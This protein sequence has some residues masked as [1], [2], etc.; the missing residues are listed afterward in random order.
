MFKRK[1]KIKYLLIF[2]CFL[3]AVQAWAGSV[4]TL[5][6]LDKDR[7]NLIINGD[8]RVSQRA[9]YTLVKDAYAYGA[10]D[11]FSG[12]AT[13]T[14]VSAG[15]LA[16]SSSAA[17]GRTGYAVHFSAATL[18]GTGIIYLRHRIEARDALIY[19][20]Q[21]ISF[22]SKVYQ[23]TGGSVNYTIYIRKANSADNFAAVTNISNSGAISVATA[24]ATNLNY[25]AIAAGDC[26]NGL[27]VE[28][29]VECGAVNNK[30]FYFAELQLE[31]GP[32]VTDFK[33]LPYAQTRVMCERYY[34]VQGGVLGT[35]PII[36]AYG[37]A[38]ATYGHGF[39]FLT[40]KRTTPTITKVGTWTVN[41]CG[42]PVVTNPSSNGYWIYIAVT[43]DGRYY[44]FP[45]DATCVVT[46]DAEL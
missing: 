33:F 5:G 15:S 27:E 46:A 40:N 24:T 21:T 39:N 16:Q 37:L 6:V 17:I 30:N 36:Y 23:D 20:N 10:V 43:G 22:S 8:C 3:I 34:E 42:Q 12:M 35:S 18:T 41:N 38:G 31:P 26:S 32:V 29:K 11:R 4:F 7:K 2:L 25:P 14:A 28:I 13:G 45:A 19:K 1:N 44:F 9:A